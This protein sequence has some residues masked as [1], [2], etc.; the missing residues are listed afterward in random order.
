[1]G[2]AAVRGLTLRDPA[3]VAQKWS[4]ARLANLGAW[5]VA[6]D[7]AQADASAAATWTG[8][9]GNAF[10][11]AT[12]SKQP[13]YYSSTSAHLING[14]PCLHFDGVDDLLVFVGTLTTSLLGHIFVVMQ[15]HSFTSSP[16]IVSSAD[17]AGT[18]KFTM[19]QILNTAFMRVTQ[20]NADSVDQVNATTTT[21][22]ADTD[23]L[24]EWASSGTVYD[25][26]VNNTVQAKS[27][28]LG[29]DNGD[30]FGDTADRDN[31][32]IGALKRTTEV[33]QFNGD[34]AEIIVLNAAIPAADRTSLNAYITENYGITLA[35]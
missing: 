4:P 5:L 21:L 29:A 35:A 31:F 34:I 25:L 20:R 23:Y 22:V 26:R 24:L 27:V 28:S 1:M 6:S 3:L 19:A 11:Q 32:V 13:L 2:A 10:A 9:V 16:G 17:E 12:G 30:W 18:Q 14:R 33:N 8:R 15:A 7:V